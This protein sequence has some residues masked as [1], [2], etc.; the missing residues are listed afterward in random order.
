MDTMWVKLQNFDLKKIKNKIWN[1]KSF[2]T[3]FFFFDS[4]AT[5][6][7]NSY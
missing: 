5:K 3:F 7:V 1:V 2:A 4:D 6:I